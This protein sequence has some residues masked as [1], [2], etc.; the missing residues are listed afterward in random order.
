MLQ[1]AKSLFGCRGGRDKKHDYFL[2][3]GKGVTENTITLWLLQGVG[4]VQRPSCPIYI[5]IY[6]Y[7]YRCIYIYICICTWL[8]NGTLASWDAFGP[9][10]QSAITTSV[11]HLNIIGRCILALEFSLQ[12]HR[13]I[14]NLQ[15]SVRRRGDHQG[16]EMRIELAVVLVDQ[17][18]GLLLVFEVLAAKR[19]DATETTDN[20]N[21]CNN[22]VHPPVH[23]QS[24]ELKC[25]SIHNGAISEWNR[26]PIAFTSCITSIHS[27]LLGQEQKDEDIK[28]ATQEKR[29]RI[30]EKKEKAN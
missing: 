20:N 1:I 21:N 9:R 5:Y 18:P 30:I 19:S 27:L 22:K 4:A 23:L 2:V 12:A 24:T 25:S 16:L 15:L 28:K 17:L 6:I 8:A 3:A 26:K 7:I 11:V 10:A 14:W 13:L 29:R